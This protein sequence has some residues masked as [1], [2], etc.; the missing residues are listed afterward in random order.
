MQD[1]H[2]AKEIVTRSRQQKICSMPS[3]EGSLEHMI[4]NP[5][6][7]FNALILLFF[8]LNEVVLLCM[9]CVAVG[10]KIA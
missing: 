6:F 7:L 5:V 2:T 9:M 1:L 10:I 3:K 4:Q 8:F